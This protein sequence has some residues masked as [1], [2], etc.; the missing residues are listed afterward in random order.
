MKKSITPRENRLLDAREQIVA[1]VFGEQPKL[2]NHAVLCALGLPYR[3]PPEDTR[4]FQRTSGQASLLLE[5]GMVPVR[6]TQHD[7]VWKPVGLPYGP[8]SRLLLLHL[9]SQS[10]KAQSPLI[11]VEDSFTAFASSIGI[12]TNGRNLKTL[13]EQI[14]RMSVVSMRLSKTY[15][16]VVDVF[17]GHLFSKFQAHTPV[18]DKQLQLWTSYVEFSPEFYSSLEHNAVPLCES[19]IKALQHS[20]RALDIYTWLAHRLHR[21]S[22]KKPV[23][24]RWTS[25]R[26][27]F[28]NRDQ[29]IKSFKRAFTT[30][31]N[32]VLCVYPNARVE[33][34]YGG[35]L[36]RQSAP[37]ISKKSHQVIA[38]SRSKQKPKTEIEQ[39][40]D[41]FVWKNV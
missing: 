41:G 40:Y 26:Q 6:E 22:P 29:S 5:A 14:L 20:A 31:L 13:R 12:D 15:G 28:G 24:I 21:I 33:S 30:A 39:S 32:Q 23:S 27:Q 2:Y 38:P 8:K 16:D 4:M 34:I 1:K 17:Q 9:C 18:D 36:L 10:I 25:L 37:P 11:E 3:K 19:A 35:I 7:T